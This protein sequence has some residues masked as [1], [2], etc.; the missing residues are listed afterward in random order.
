MSKTILTDCDGVLLDWVEGFSAWMEVRGFQRLPDYEY[1]YTI[2]KWYDLTHEE[3]MEHV[4]IYNASAGI[5]FLPPYLDSVKYVKL[6]NEVYGYRFIVITAMGHDPYAIELRKRNL[7]EVFGDVFDDVKVVGLLK[8]KREILE[9]Y[10]PTIW[11][12]DKPSAAEEGH[13]VGHRTFL[14]EHGH[15]GDMSTSHGITRVHEWKEIYN[16][17]KALELGTRDFCLSAKE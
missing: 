9:L 2:E 13:E 4:S 17:I 14:F 6:L 8:S 16:E 11:I 15:N 5:G 1:H 7:Q 12:E 10:E 3:A